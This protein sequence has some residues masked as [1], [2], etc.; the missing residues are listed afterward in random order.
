MNK[1]NKIKRNERVEG[2]R[3]VLKVR[4]RKG[5]EKKDEQK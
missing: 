4:R 2:K 1:E 3:S 5:N